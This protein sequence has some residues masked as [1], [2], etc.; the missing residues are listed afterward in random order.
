MI[1]IKDMK[2]PDVCANCKFC[3]RDFDVALGQDVWCCRATHF[4]LLC[5]IRKEKQSWCPLIEVEIK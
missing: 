1:A 5:D 4:I 2:M 3:E